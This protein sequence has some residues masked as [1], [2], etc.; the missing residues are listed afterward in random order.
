[1]TNEVSIRITASDATQAVRD[2]MKAEL[3]TSGFDAGKEYGRKFK[4][5]TE[6][7]APA[8][9]PVEAKNPIDEAWR[10]QVQASIRGIA[11][12]A[13]KIPMSP[14]T[15]AYREELRVAVGELQSSLKQKI[16]VDIDQ[17]D[18]FKLR[19]RELADEVSAE[20]KAKI[21]VEADEQSANDAGKQAGD[22]FVS[23]LTGRQALIGTAIAAGVLGGGPVIVAAGIATGVGMLTALGA[24]IQKGNPAIQAGW[25]KLQADA[26]AAAQGASAG[27]VAPLTQAMGQIDNLI[28][29][30]QPEFTKLFQSAAADVPILTQGLDTLVSTSLPGLN[31]GLAN[32]QS[33]V[34][35]TSTLMGDLGGAVGQIGSQFGQNSAEVTTSLH[36]LGSVVDQTGTSVSTLLDFS[37]KLASGALPTLASGLNGVLGAADGVLHVLGPMAPMLGQIAV[38]GA[39]AWASFKLAGLASVGVVALSKGLDSLSVGLTGAGAKMLDSSLGSTRAGAAMAT[40]AGEG[41][42]FAGKAASLA[43]TVAGPLGIALGLGSMALMLFGQNSDQAAQKQQEQTQAAQALTQALEQSGGAVDANVRSTLAQQLTTDSNANTLKKYGVSLGDMEQKLL[44]GSGAIDAQVATLQKQKDAI[45]DS[46][47]SYGSAGARFG[48][49]SVTM[50]QGARSQIAS[51][52]D[53]SQAWK[54]LQGDLGGSLQTQRDYADLV[55]KSAQALG[56]HTDKL[57]A[58]QTALEAFDSTMNNAAALYMQNTSAIRQYVDATV[59]AAGANVTAAQQFQQLDQAVVQAQQSV[60]SAATGIA[61]AQ[62]SLVDAGHAVDAARHSEQQAVQGVTDAQYSYQQALLSEKQAQTSL[63]AARQA[64]ADQLAALQRQVV[65]QGDTEAEAKLRLVQAQEAVDKAGLHGKTLAGLGDPTAANQTQYDLLLKLQEAQHNLNDVNA[66]TADLNKQNATAQA[67]GINGAAGVIQAQQ[68]LASAQH[69][70]QAASKAV[71][72]AQYAEKQASQAVEDAIWSQHS[73]QLALT[74]A[75]QAGLKAQQ[76]LTNA[77]D[78]DARTLDINTQAGQRNWQ[79]VEDMYNKNYAVTHSVADATAA[80]EDETTKL[81]FNQGAVQGVIDTLNGLSGKNF[82]FSVTGTPTLDLGPVKGILQDPTL[83]LFTNQRG[84]SGGIASAGRLAAGGH[85]NGPGGPTDDAIHAMLSA[86]EYVQPADSVN[87]YGVEYMDA[88]RKKRLPRYASGGPVSPTDLGGIMGLNAGAA[89]GWGLYETAG[90]TANAMGARPQLPTKMPA[91]GNFSR[92]AFAGA[93]LGSSGPVPG[94]PSSRAANEAIVNAIWA[95]YGWNAGAEWDATVHLLMQESGFNNTAQ[96]P[97]ST[98][99]GMF[100]FLDTTW[101]GYGVP[102]TSDPTAQSIAGGRYLKSRYGDPLGA[103]AHE[104]AFNWYGA[105]GPAGGLIGVGD[106][107]PELINV[108]NGS[109]VMSNVDSRSV[110]AGSNVAPEIKVTLDVGGTNSGLATLIMNMIR[111]GEIQILSQYIHK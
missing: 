80:T 53:Q 36:A 40:A 64:A 25:A 42:N 10:A 76:D 89:A 48:E 1:M 29:R 85:I 20:V 55:A 35:A 16:P 11:A 19:V 77:K 6:K 13:I 91:A 90:L 9:V 88:I 83:G 104:R 92:G 23:G 94:V 37:T 41:A 4:E 50:T 66:Q 43:S 78:A 15:A 26:T 21:P 49:T 51:L 98:A 17:A 30:E 65:D 68:Q 79:T 34:K 46:A 102:K 95:G 62:H 100:Q 8:K 18:Q 14:D 56:I 106:R 39:E 69:G 33:V 72:D 22:S 63:M 54:K 27:M 101:A 103:W 107:G 28:Q 73:A 71:S 111:N 81:G 82:A 75:Q 70:V 3:A 108:P 44:Q 7:Q 24:T 2:K 60:D 74:Q 12:D 109:T 110:L 52:D 96:N 58:G 31:A 87:Y 32:S 99:Y 61:S 57:S 38:Y 84:S 97:T 67:A 5:S 47:S 93:G 45:A 86:G 59:A 105:G